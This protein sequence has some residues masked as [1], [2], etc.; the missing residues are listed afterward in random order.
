[1]AH[2]IAV[3]RSGSLVQIGTPEEI[4]RRPADTFVARDWLRRDGDGRDVSDA[5]GVA[6]E[7]CDGLGCVLHRGVV[8]AVSRR[9]EALEEDCMHAHILVSAVDAD[10]GLPGLVIDRRAAANGEGWAI[11]LSPLHAQSVREWRGARPWVPAP[12]TAE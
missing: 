8:I 5:V 2:R 4:W 7:K 10:C 9:P 3:M 1:M 11:S 6:G 12:N